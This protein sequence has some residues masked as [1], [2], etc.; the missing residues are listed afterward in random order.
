MKAAGLPAG[1]EYVRRVSANQPA[2]GLHLDGLHT[3]R[4]LSDG[5]LRAPGLPT[6]GCNGHLW[7]L[8]RVVPMPT[9]DGVH[10]SPLSRD[11]AQ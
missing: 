9:G 4:V 11:M 1:W 8:A 3:Y 2:K 5:Q 10:K 7:R 6:I